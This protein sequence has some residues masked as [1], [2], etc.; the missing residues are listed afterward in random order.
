MSQSLV[1]ILSLKTSQSLIVTQKLKKTQKVNLMMIQILMVLLNLMVIQPLTM[2]MPMKVKFVKMVQLLKPDH[3][4]IV[5]SN[6][7]AKFD[8]LQDTK[9]DS[10]G[11]VI[12]CAMLVDSKPV[13]VE[14]VLKKKV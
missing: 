13:S 8:M 9:I 4:G 12:Q 7:F 10:E 11:E 2:V 1:I 6:R 3:K 5:R 14:E